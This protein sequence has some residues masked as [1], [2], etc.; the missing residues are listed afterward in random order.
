MVMPTSYNGYIKKNITEAEKAQLCMSS[1]SD[2]DT[3]L[4]LD[5]P[6]VRLAESDNSHNR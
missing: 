4:R 2:P 5:H 3:P 1:S 6:S